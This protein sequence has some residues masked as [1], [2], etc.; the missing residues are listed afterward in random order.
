M[1]R[2]KSDK[3]ALIAIGN[4]EEADDLIREMGDFQLKINAAQAKAKDD[5]D[6]TKAELAAELKPINSELEHYR[7][8]L[9]AFATSRR[10]E[11][12]KQKSLKLNYGTIGWRQ[13][14]SIRIKK[15]TLELIKKIFSRAKAARFIHTK[16]TVDKGA[17]AKL[18]D[19]QLGKL[20]ARREGM[21]V[22]FVELE[23][24]D[25]VDYCE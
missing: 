1:A 11:L 19:Q 21:D 16:E 5:I 15:T 18:T 10:A 13:S 2:I 17:L 22:F 3:T 20:A 25:A 12:K 6:E 9:E 24:P 4:W 8:S 23:L 14:T 7:K